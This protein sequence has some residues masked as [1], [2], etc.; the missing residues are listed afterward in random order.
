MI[1]DDNQK[2]MS[3]KLKKCYVTEIKQKNY[4]DRKEKNKVRK[5]FNSV[6]GISTNNRN[7]KS[8][9]STL[10]KSKNDRRMTFNIEN[11]YLNEDKELDIPK[12]REDIFNLSA[13]K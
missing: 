11:N 3:S 8:Q 2:E 12:N 10:Q 9:Y 4:Q 7:K 1:S 5:R 6:I 13:V